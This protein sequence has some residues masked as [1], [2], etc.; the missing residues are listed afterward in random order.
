MK[1]LFYLL[2]PLLFCTCRDNF[3]EEFEKHSMI[4]SGDAHLDEFE[5]ELVFIDEEVYRDKLGTIQGSLGPL[6]S[7]G[8][9]VEWSGFFG[10]EVVE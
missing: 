9:G 6:G 1:N 3:E 2:L 10:F 4:D 7:E 5:E 8:I